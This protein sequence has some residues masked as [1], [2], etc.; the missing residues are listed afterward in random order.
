MGKKVY[1]PSWRYSPEGEARIFDRPEDVPVD[2]FASKTEAEAYA[3]SQASPPPDG[4]DYWGGHPKQQLVQMLR[5]HGEK[6]HAN[7]SSRKAYE[8]AVELG[9]IEVKKEEEG[10]AVEEGLVSKDDIE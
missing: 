6:V 9:L 8:K 1:W 5:K 7:I 4:A 3:A 10:H 2:W